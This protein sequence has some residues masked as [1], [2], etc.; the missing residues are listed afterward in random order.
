MSEGF[1]ILVFDI[2][3]QN[4]IR[5]TQNFGQKIKFYHFWWL[6]PENP[7]NQLFTRNQVKNQEPDE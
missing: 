4:Y 2:L 3:F 6:V 1:Q 5:T 7:K